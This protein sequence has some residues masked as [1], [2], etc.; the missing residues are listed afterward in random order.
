VEV[1][2]EACE[3]LPIDAP[4]H[5][6]LVGNM[7]SPDLTARIGASPYRDRIHVLGFR[8]DAPAVIA[9]CDAAVL[10]SIK[11]EGLPKTVIEAMAYGVPPIVTDCG[12][13]PELV[14]DG[15]SGLVVPVR[16]PLAIGRAIRKLYEDAGLRARLGRAA[17]ERIRN[18][19]RIEDTIARTLA[20]YRSLAADDRHASNAIR[21]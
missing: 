19:F 13:S 18:D 1:L 3:S 4:I 20:L 11:R 8:A 7:D 17:R 21:N 16:D 9:G 14:V 15:V 5:V 10:P 6:L 12:G 2:I